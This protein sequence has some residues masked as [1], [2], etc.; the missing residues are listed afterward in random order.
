MSSHRP[1]VSV[2]TPAFRAAAY[3]E[4]TISSVR[5]Q[6]FSDWEM[7][8]VDDASRDG[9]AEI[10]SS[11][12][13]IEPRIR[14]EIAPQNRGPGPTRNRALELARGRYV[15]FLDAD[16][17]W[18]P[19]K[20]QRQLTW[21]RSRGDAFTFT[22]YRVVSRE[23]EVR[24]EISA[25]P[26]HMHYADL[27]K[28]TVIGCLTVVLDRDQTGPLSFPALRTSQDT[29]LWLSLLKRGMVAVG[30]PEVLA[31]YRL[32][33]DSNTRNKL[34]AAKGVWELYRGHEHLSVPRCA[35]Y[36]ANYAI[37]GAMKHFT[38]GAAR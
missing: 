14:W 30:I 38:S 15:A 36:F 22:G 4:K 26:E 29:A 25:I 10:L 37:R 16:D 19:P 27:L 5:A 12:S 2:I 7:I 8:I 32:V 24:G 35:W 1:V 33:G 31:S 9:T 6:T 20:L 28:N 21:M 34:K 18:D 17:L 23:G 3:L 11:Q 13:T